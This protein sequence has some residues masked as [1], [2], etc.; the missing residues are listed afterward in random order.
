MRTK[1]GLTTGVRE[2]DLGSLNL[3]LVFGCCKIN[4]VFKIHS[5]DLVCGLFLP[6]HYVLHQII[7]FEDRHFNVLNPCVSFDPMCV[8]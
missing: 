4:V 7:D 3:S 6:L 2:I 5:E 1:D 8:I